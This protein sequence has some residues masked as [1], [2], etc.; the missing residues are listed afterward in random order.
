MSNIVKGTF[1][2]ALMLLSIYFTY[3]LPG[4]MNYCLGFDKNYGETRINILYSAYSIPNI[5]LPYFF[6]HTTYLSKHAMSLLLASFVLS[7]QLVFSLGTHIKSFTLMIVGR[8]IFGIGSESYSVIQNKILSEKFKAV[9]LTEAMIFY[10]T[11][12]KVGTILAFIL[13]PMISNVFGPFP[14]NILS[15]ILIS[16]GFHNCYKSYIEIKKSAQ[17]PLEYSPIDI[18][19]DNL[20]PIKEI[21][22][23]NGSKRQAFW[24]LLIFCLI[25]GMIW[26]PF[27]NIAPMMYQKRFYLSSNISSFTVSIIECISM[28]MSFFIRPILRGRGNKLNLII[29]GMIVLIAAHLSILTNMFGAYLS[30]I[31]LGI[32]AS[33]ISFYWACIPKIVV[34]EKLSSAYGIIYCITN[35]AFTISPLLV[36]LLTVRSP[37]YFLVEVYLILLSVTGL[38]ILLL[39][40][41][42]NTSNNLK[43]NEIDD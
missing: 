40:S 14:A 7:G 24:L 36:A 2:P 27:Y 6:S 35:L 19:I 37:T 1:M 16:I 42:K 18:Q 43:L 29:F 22:Q 41:Y 3:D 12:G 13:V 25:F 34:E 17:Q 5:I 11:C 30:V 10:N 8:I 9:D 31:L 39:L 21:N 4:S 23:E 33:F 20:A 38:A 15:C 26:S 32:S 28:M